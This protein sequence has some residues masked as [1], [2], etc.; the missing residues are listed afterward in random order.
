MLCALHAFATLACATEA[1][2]GANGVLARRI[3]IDGIIL[4]RRLAEISGIAHSRLTPN[5]LWVVNDSG[6]KN[7]IYA[8]DNDGALQAAVTISGTSN[9]DWEDLASFKL[10]GQAY[11][12]IA[13]TGDNG[14]V[15]KDAV[16]YVVPE[17]KMAK[18]G[19]PRVVD[20]LWSVRFHWPKKPLDCEA[21]AVDA[22][23]RQILLISKREAPAKL[24]SLR[25]EDSGTAQTAQL[26]GEFAHL[27]KKPIV[28]PG[29]IGIAARY[30]NQATSMAI[31]PSGTS[32]AVLTYGDAYLFAKPKA[33]SWRAA[34]GEKPNALGLPTLPQAEAITFGLNDDAL[35]AT[36]EKL[37]APL[38]KIEIAPNPA[39][40]S[41][42]ATNKQTEGS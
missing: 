1:K 20:A 2:S 14:G 9:Y 3:I 25:L 8:I 16:I 12:A 19:F 6:G 39:A 33:R 42:P 41:K 15:R 4:D 23:N 30:R 7:A 18:G 11:L 26:V 27:P 28:G 38:L 24:Y 36:S 5:L 34:L 31:A 37:P 40:R 35:W 32:F 13:D 10:R 17:P 22:A 21:I 29:R